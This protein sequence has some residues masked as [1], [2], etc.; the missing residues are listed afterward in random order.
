M[1]AGAE[2][3]AVDWG[4]TLLRVWAMRGDE[5]MGAA[6]SDRGMAT[7]ARG[8]F[9]AV[10]MEL[11]GH[12]IVDGP[13]DAI[14]CGMA[15]AR[16]GWIEAPY[17]TVPA[18]PRSAPPIRA[19]ANDPRLCAHVL[20]G[21]KQADPA[22]VMRGEET[23]I[24]GF[25]SLN[26]NWDGMICLPGTHSKWAHISANK[27]TGF[28]TFM[29]GELFDL[30]GRSSIL[31]HSASEGWDDG[32]FAEGLDDSLSDPESLTTRLFGIRA[33]NLLDEKTAAVGRARLSGLLIGVE[34]AAMRRWW[35]DRPLAVIGA[36][37]MADLYARALECQGVRA[38]VESGREMAL[39]G[40]K[41]AYRSLKA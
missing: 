14:I 17:A 21:L 2:W 6:G 24:A 28:R 11:A 13:V 33:R 35:Q 12:W 26:Q 7:V 29:T 3:I 15:G 1:S 8:G 4:T 38:A 31:R 32:A 5:V 9:E 37:D 39:A 22:D 34:L 30:L 16:Q 10:L 36:P 40:L 25:L 20:G 23:Q 27:V 19:P 41:A 18:S